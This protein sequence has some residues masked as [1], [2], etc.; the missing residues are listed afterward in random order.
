MGRKRG[1]PH[2]EPGAEALEA[3]AW[4]AEMERLAELDD[5]ALLAEYESPFAEYEAHR[6]DAMRRLLKALSDLRGQD[7]PREALT[8]AVASLREGMARGGWI[9]TPMRRAAGWRPKKLPKDDAELW[10]GAAG[11]LVEARKDT[12]LGVDEDSLATSIDFA[13]WLGAVIG[14][15]RA[16]VGASA[17]PEDLVRYINECPEIEGTIDSEDEDLVASGFEIVL[18]AWEAAGAID[19]DRRLTELGRWGLPRALAW[20][21]YGNFDSGEVPPF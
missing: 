6:E 9:H 21:W 15:V 19:R 10:L 12:G 11:G 3:G 8:V 5:E 17:W 4:M 20:A 1:Q 7:P 2:P 16:G 13:D 14:L 18:S